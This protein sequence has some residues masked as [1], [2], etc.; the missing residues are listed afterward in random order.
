MSNS[1]IITEL[2]AYTDSEVQ[3]NALLFITHITAEETKKIT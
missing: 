1:K 2:A 3:S